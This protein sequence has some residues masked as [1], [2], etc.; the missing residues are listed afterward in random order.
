MSYPADLLAETAAHPPCGED[1]TYFP[2]FLAMEAAAR[3]KC[4]QQFGDTVIAAEAPEW[5]LV[6]RQASALM[7]RTKDLRVV[8]VLC[9]AW[10]NVRGLI[11]TAQGLQLTADLLER[12]WDQVHPLPEDEDDH[13]MRMN[14]VAV[15]GDVTGLVRELRDTEFLRATFG[16]VSVREAEALARGHGGDSNGAVSPDQLRAAVAEAWT[17]GSEA[18]RAV[19]L[20]AEALTRIQALCASKLPIHQLPELDP[21]QGLL[22]TLHDL[23]PKAVEAV[24]T[25]PAPCDEEPATAPGQA[26]PRGHGPLRDREDAIAQLLRIAEFVER[27]EPTNPAPLLIHRAVKLMRMNFIDILRELSPAGLAQVEVATGLR[28]DA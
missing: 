2:E 21:L 25:E 18:L 27:S 14:A 5:R 13:Y 17:R 19:T 26:A 9:R 15:L 3:G 11:G 28:S 12:Y 7:E 16:S 20:A 4:E 24:T 6:E 8:A 23:L 22:Q 10:T 1:L